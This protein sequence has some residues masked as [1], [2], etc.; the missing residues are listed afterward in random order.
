[1]EE[2]LLQENIF[3]LADLQ[4][5]LS[6]ITLCAKIVNPGKGKYPRDVLKIRPQKT[7]SLL[8]L[9]SH[10]HMG[11]PK[12]IIKVAAWKTYKKIKQISTTCLYQVIFKI[13]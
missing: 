6:L 4:S 10:Y 11:L 8:Y 13:K 2:N 1:M 7:I 9:I 3:Q 5:L 12:K